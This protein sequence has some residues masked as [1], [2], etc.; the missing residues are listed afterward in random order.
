MMNKEKIDVILGAFLL[1]NIP[2]IITQEEFDDV[3][4]A[5]K[6][7]QKKAELT[8]HYKHLYS[9][10]KKQKDEIF[11]YIKSFEYYIPEDNKNELLGML[12]EI[13]VED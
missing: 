5:I 7:L 1:S 8:D 3:K 12:G 4:S 9:E 2:E 11:K 6:D 13:D 10:L